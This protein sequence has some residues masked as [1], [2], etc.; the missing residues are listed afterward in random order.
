[1]NPYDVLG[2]ASGADLGEIRKAYRK[3]ARLL[4]PDLHPGDAEKAA[5]L[6][7]VTQAFTILS[8]PEKRASIDRPRAT[9][10]VPHGRGPRAAT[11]EE[12]RAWRA[13]AYGQQPTV[14]MAGKVYV[15]RPP[16]DFP[17]GSVRLVP[18][19][20]TMPAVRLF[21]RKPR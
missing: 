13:R 12:I 5:R 3:L 16:H 18:G 6:A 11:E 10:G 2:V 8:D 15:V 7:I 17:A 19:A 20:F 9:G 21:V 4:H 14:Q 1:M